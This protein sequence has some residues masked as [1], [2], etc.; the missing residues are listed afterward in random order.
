MIEPD[1]YFARLTSRHNF[2]RMDLMDPYAELKAAKDGGAMILG[3]EHDG[4]MHHI[5]NPEWSCPP[6]RY[7]AVAKWSEVKPL[8]DECIKLGETIKALGIPL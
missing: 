2:T 3:I 4:R 6:D 1:D 8:L 7:L 5:E